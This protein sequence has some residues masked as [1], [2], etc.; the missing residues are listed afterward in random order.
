MP[1]PLPTSVENLYDQYAGD[2]YLPKGS[3]TMTKPSLAFFKDRVEYLPLVV[4]L[5]FR[6]IFLITYPL[7]NSGY[8]AS[9]YY[10]MI[11]S[12]TSSLV[13]ASG[14]PF[15]F[16]LF[17]SKI[18]GKE[19]ASSVSLDYIFLISQHLID[20]CIIIFCFYHL[21]KLYSWVPASIYATLYGLSTWS[22]SWVSTVYPEWLQADLFLL[23]LIFLQLALKAQ[24]K[25]YKY[26]YYGFSSLCFIWAF[27]TKF[28]TAPFILIYAAILI[29]E[30]SSWIKRFAYLALIAGIMIINLVGFELFYHYPSTGTFSLT[31]DKGWVLSTNLSF[32]KYFSEKEFEFSEESGIYTQRFLALVKV[33]PSNY[34]DMAGPYLFSNINAIPEETRK[35]YRDNYL[36]IFSADSENLKSILTEKKLPENFNL[37]YSTLPISYYIGL[38]ESDD[39]FSMVFLEAMRACPG[40]FFQKN[41]TTFSLVARGKFVNLIPLAPV[42]PRDKYNLANYSLMIKQTNGSFSTYQELRGFEPVN[43]PYY[44]T[45]RIVLWRPGLRLFSAMN[46]YLEPHP[47]IFTITFLIGFG[48]SF[49][50]ILYKRLKDYEQII[51]ILL[52]LMIVSF[53]NYSNFVL[54]FRDKELRAIYP[55]ISILMSINL[56]WVIPKF[57]NALPRM[58]RF[59]L[60]GK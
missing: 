27:L 47:I 39:L 14:Y 60:S 25:T 58:F 52:F 22:T 20:Y 57:I 6:I 29:F 53:V 23:A 34:S 13:H 9:N 30:N 50:T 41:I 28:N 45:H 16:W 42:Y 46:N 21:K 37:G 43:I 12:G 8:D 2:Y 40:C 18:L 17:F 59:V 51:P 55:L 38:E 31:S 3:Y 44:N 49:V 1:L 19:L 7:N 5:I 4:V 11:I 56:G 24:E 32:Q 35:P 15:L 33:L 26:L 10:N 36:Y 48:I 54:I